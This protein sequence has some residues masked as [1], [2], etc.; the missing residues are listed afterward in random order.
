MMLNFSLSCSEWGHLHVFT[1]GV[2]ECRGDNLCWKSRLTDIDPAA[3]RP[4]LIYLRGP[5]QQMAKLLALPTG[6][7][8]ELSMADRGLMNHGQ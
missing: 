2:R 3:A 7:A 1:V 4:G 6:W 5:L 8:V